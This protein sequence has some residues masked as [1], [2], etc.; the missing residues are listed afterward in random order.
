MYVPQF[1]YCMS[2]CVSSFKVIPQS[3][4]INKQVI[5]QKVSKPQ[6]SLYISESFTEQTFDCG[7]IIFQKNIVY[8]KGELLFREKLCYMAMTW[9]DPQFYL[10]PELRYFL[11]HRW[12]IQKERINLSKGR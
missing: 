8:C 11:L 3:L 1:N 6:N 5:I 2:A 7:F 9:Q 4:S 12:N 10:S